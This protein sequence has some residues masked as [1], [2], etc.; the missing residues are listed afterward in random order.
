MASETSRCL[1]FLHSTTATHGLGLGHVDR[2]R[3]LGRHRACGGTTAT[4]AEASQN[5]Q[6]HHDTEEWSHRISLDKRKEIDKR[7]L[8]LDHAVRG[9]VGR[10]VLVPRKL[11]V[12]IPISGR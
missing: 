3:F 10:A 7:L 8:L 11:L 4:S 5:N 12:H 2:L 9:G 6:K 1:F